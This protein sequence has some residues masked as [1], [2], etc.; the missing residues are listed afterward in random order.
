MKGI[1]ILKFLIDAVTAHNSSLKKEVTSTKDSSYICYAD[2]FIF[3]IEFVEGRV[4]KRFGKRG[5]Q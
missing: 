5:L 3:V 1:H 2:H 4:K